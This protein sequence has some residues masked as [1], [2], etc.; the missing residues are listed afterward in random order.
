[1]EYTPATL[2][3][4]TMV[5]RYRYVHLV[6]LAVDVLALVGMVLYISTFTST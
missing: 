3:A 2:V 6:L 5:R 4:G 1:M